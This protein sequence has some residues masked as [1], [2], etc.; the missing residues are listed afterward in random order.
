MEVIIDKGCGLDVHKQSVVACIMGKDIKKD[1]QT[2]GTYT[3]ELV[4]LKKWLKDNGI[5]H[6]AMESTGVYWKPIFNILEDE[7]EILLV[8]ARHIKN[9][10]GRKTDV[11]DSEWICK[12]LRAGLLRG[13]FIPPRDIRELRDLTR[14]EQKLVN[15]ISSEK[16]RIQKVLEDANIKLSS[17]VSNMF[18]V[19]ATKIVEELLKGELTP[20][21]LCQF[22]KG[23]LAPKKEEIIKAVEGKLTSHHKLM[24]EAS[25]EHIKAM[26]NIIDTID[27]QINKLLKKHNEEYELLQ[28]IPG[29]KEKAATAI[30]AEIGTNMDQFPTEDH[31]CSWAGIAP[32]NNESAGKKKSGK[33]TKGSKALKNILVQSAWAASKTKDTYLSSKYKSLV[34]RRGKKRALIA[35][36]HKILQIAYFIIKDKQPYKELGGNYLELRKE[37]TIVKGLKKRFEKLGYK[38]KIQ[39]EEAKAA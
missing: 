8:N 19:T 18:G 26:E 23:R 5:T 12:L 14:Y 3:S 1:I 36:A 32:G 9:V 37:Q 11:S 24:I 2:F 28:T 34:G 16:N 22:A 27:I 7:F 30:I 17:V 38:V 33:I 13:S 15:N 35:V 29:V 6:I 10:P 4:S 20:Q 39:K 31:L 21:E 25:L